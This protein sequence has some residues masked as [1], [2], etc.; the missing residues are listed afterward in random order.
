MEHLLEIARK[1]A[2]AVT[3]FGTSYTVD[4]VRFDNARLK[5]V[6]THLNSGTAIT[7]AKDGKQGFAYTRNLIDRE[8][9]VRD[10]LAALAGGVEAAG[11]LPRPV[12]LPT[13]DT[14]VEHVGGSSVLVDECRRIVE[15]LSSQTKGQV[16]AA[17]TRTT[18]DQRVLT[19]SG[20]DA[21]SLSTSY[22]SYGAVLYPGTQA[23][24]FR[25][26]SAK[27]LTPFPEEDLRFVA[28]TYNASQ[29]EVKASSGRSKVLFLP[30]TAYALIWRLIEATHARNVYEKVSPLVD[31][32]GE[33]VLSDKL[34]LRDEPLN[35]S[36][37]GARAFDDEGTPCRNLTLFER[38]TL[39]AFYNN[40]FYAHKLGVKPTGHGWRGDV[41][42]QPEAS[43]GHLTMAPGEHAFE[44]ML[45]LMGRG[46]I[47]VMALGA[48]SGNRL[49]GEYS[50]G[51]AP[52]LLV[53]DG[54]IVGVIKDSL[55]TGN[56][57][58][59]LKKVMDVENRVHDAPM[60]YFPSLL[61]DDIS[62][63]TRS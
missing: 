47:G 3:V 29:K 20:V 50:I 16:N 45:K 27:S 40:R 23:N 24:V 52:G 46:V 56:V 61:L 14:A 18:S 13:L 62:F 6:D 36:L 54:R 8:G 26:F 25:G 32:I 38:G 1:Q 30:Y 63:T 5:A 42:A 11:D 60:G 41:T 43:L 44:Q 28:E 35:D 33:Q 22:G 21:R 37:P 7:V 53:E 4:S 10:A 9:L 57:Y 48:H 51:L 34:T 19:S 12:E 55:A 58:E 31:R 49:S 39:K 59:D 15:Y 2:D 17:A